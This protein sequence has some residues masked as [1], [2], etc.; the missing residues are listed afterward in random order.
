MLLSSCP[1][2]ADMRVDSFS[3]ERYRVRD[4]ITLLVLPVRGIVFTEVLDTA[5][6]PPLK[7]MLSPRVCL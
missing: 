1:A 7:F 2:T 5:F 6:R 4:A 3:D